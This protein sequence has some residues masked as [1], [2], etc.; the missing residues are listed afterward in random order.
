MTGYAEYA[1]ILVFVHEISTSA[2]T[3][4]QKSLVYFQEIDSDAG[5]NRV[6]GNSPC[7][8]TSTTIA[9]TT[10]SS[11]HKSEREVEGEREREGGQSMSNGR[12]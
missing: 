1:C 3:T 9:S 6:R 2:P 8:S 5:R 7:Q 10:T 12:N 11:T 4:L